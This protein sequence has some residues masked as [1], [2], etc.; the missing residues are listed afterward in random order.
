MP[1]ILTAFVV[2]GLVVALPAFAGEAEGSTVSSFAKYLPFVAVFNGV[3]AILFTLSYI[4]GAEEKWIRGLGLILAVTVLYTVFVLI[5]WTLSEVRKEKRQ[6][7]YES[8]EARSFSDIR[9][10]QR[11]C[12]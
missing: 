5:F 7:C 9:A 12:R 1:R 11:N 6:A 4:L 8:C 10:C 2:I 3:P